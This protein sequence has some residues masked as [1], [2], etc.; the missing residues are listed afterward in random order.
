MYDSGAGAG[1]GAAEGVRH[2]P[3]VPLPLLC[4]HLPGRRLPAPGRRPQ[5]RQGRPRD[6]RR[7][8]AAVR[9]LHRPQLRPGPHPQGAGPAGAA[10]PPLPAGCPLPARHPGWLLAPPRR[11][12]PSAGGAALPGLL[13]RRGAG[14]VE[15]P[16]AGAVA[17]DHHR[18]AA[19]PGPAGR[20][21][22]RPSCGGW[23]GSLRQGGRVPAARARSTSMPSSAWTRPPCAAAPAAWP[24]HPSRSRPTCSR[25][26]CGRRS[27][28]CRVP[29][30][31]LDDGGPARYA[32]WG[33]QLDV[34]NITADRDGRRGS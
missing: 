5:G 19:C 8:S 2:P 25:T 28:R 3:G 10:L 22:A 20:P 13:R 14:A 12:R 27:R 9:D 30:P 1:R 34:R 11:G 15:R 21:P 18:P 29:C 23:S 6:R 32:R 24:H 31:A 16:G 4:G 33:E 7:A 26:P 17:A